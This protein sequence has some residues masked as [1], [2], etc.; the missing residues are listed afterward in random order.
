M[1]VSRLLLAAALCGCSS[2][3]DL[4]PVGGAWFSEHVGSFNPDG[5]GHTALYRRGGDSK[6]VKV[7][8][9][10]YIQA[11]LPPDCI[12]FDSRDLAGTVFAVCGDR[13][14]VAVAQD[15]VGDAGRE[16][17]RDSDGLH[18][19]ES[20]QVV[21]GRAM[22]TVVRITMEQMRAAAEAQPPFHADWKKRPGAS[23]IA[24]DPERVE[25]PVQPSAASLL[26]AVQR[27]EIDAMIALIQSGAPVDAADSRR[28]TS[29][30]WAVLKDDTTAFRV[31]LERGADPCRRD[32]QNRTVAEIGGPMHTELWNEAKAATARCRGG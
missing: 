20:M 29:L 2:R 12:V 4:Q 22:E 26:R 28:I 7:D 3:P 10:L 21:N 6:M 16:F 1:A 24:I 14:P 8:E 32:N 31:L 11:F 23:A 19:V 18:R 17:V 25:E 30:M 15:A 13:T 27:G 5:K 9:G